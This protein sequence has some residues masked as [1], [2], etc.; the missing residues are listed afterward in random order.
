VISDGAVDA[1][2]VDLCVNG[3]I[4]DKSEEN[5]DESAES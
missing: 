4:A 2:A 3:K 5:G 1:S